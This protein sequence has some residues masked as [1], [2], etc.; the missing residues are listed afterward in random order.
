MQKHLQKDTEME[1]IKQI[2]ESHYTW[3][4]G[5]MCNV[6]R[7]TNTSAT[8]DSATFKKLHAKIKETVEKDQKNILLYDI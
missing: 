4:E 6:R 1:K 5:F 2:F 3:I 7:N 8:I